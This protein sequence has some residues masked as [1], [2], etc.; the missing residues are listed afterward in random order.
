M[1]RNG[2]DGRSLDRVLQHHLLE[3]SKTRANRFVVGGKVELEYALHNGK[4]H[5]CLVGAKAALLAEG[6]V[7]QVHVQEYVALLHAQHIICGVAQVLLQL[8][9]PAGARQR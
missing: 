5:R 1:L 4:E 3:A 6:Q 8:P 9:A 2:P 7:V